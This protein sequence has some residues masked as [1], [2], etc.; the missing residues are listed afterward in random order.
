MDE[1]GNIFVTDRLKNIIKT[2][3]MSH[4]IDCIAI[5]F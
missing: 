1:K 2:K 5:V 4:F 3:V